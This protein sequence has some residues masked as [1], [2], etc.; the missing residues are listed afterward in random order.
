MEGIVIRPPTH[1]RQLAFAGDVY[2]PALNRIVTS[3]LSILSLGVADFKFTIRSIIFTFS[4]S[5]I[6]LWIE[7]VVSLQYS[8]RISDEVAHLG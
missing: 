1:Q 8:E 5:C 7:S 4:I 3:L 6:L 2:M